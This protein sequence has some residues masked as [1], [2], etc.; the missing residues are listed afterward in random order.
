MGIGRTLKFIPR[1]L[2]RVVTS[3]D[4]HFRET[5]LNKDGRKESGME[6]R[7]LVGREPQSG[8]RRLCLRPGWWEPRDLLLRG[9]G[10]REGGQDKSGT[11]R[12]CWLWEG[13]RARD[14]HTEDI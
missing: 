4:S 12:E 10:R 9:A 2:S 11:R 8:E 13:S 7:L 5:S 3:S 6:I 14:T 1:V